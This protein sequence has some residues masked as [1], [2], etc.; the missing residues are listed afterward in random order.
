M[1]NVLLLIIV[2]SL[3][4]CVS[5]SREPSQPPAIPTEE[6]P[7]VLTS[8]P[9]HEAFAEPVDLNIQP[10][11]IVPAQPPANIKETLPAEK[12]S[13]Q[14]VWVPG[15][16]AWD[17]Q[18]N[19]Y[20]WVSGCWRTAP[21]NMYWVPG[22]WLK[23]SDGWQ[24]VSGF[25]APTSGIGRIEYLP[26]PPELVDIKPPVITVSSDKIWVP[27]CW[28]WR[29]G[30]YIL[31]S[32]Y[33]VT[34]QPDWIWEPSHYVWTPRG[35]VF[36]AGHWDYVLS[37][38]GVLFAP[39][40][41]PGRVYERPDFSYSLS[42]VIDIGNLNFGLF[43]YPHY[44]HYY[45]GDY[46]DD[47]YLSIGI[48]PW[49]ESRSRYVWY[50]P[51]YEHQHWRYSRGEP[52]WEK[53]HRDD[54]ERRRADRSLRP[55]RTYREMEARVEKMP[56]IK[57]TEYWTAAPLKTVITEKRDQIR[58]EPM[59]NDSRQRISRKTT[60]V[61]DFG[62]ERKQWESEKPIQK[63]SKEMSPPARANV[64]ERVKTTSPP[65]SDKQG[66]FDIFRKGP[67]SR[68]ANEKRTEAGGKQ[69]QP[70]PGNN[71]DTPRQENRRDRR[72]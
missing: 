13:G 72:G 6:N 55:A 58:F 25:W 51:I 69:S 46:Y 71:S 56:F 49:F 16:W 47:V 65:I 20:I 17:S 23:I 15:Y 33:W 32:G 45:F 27:P 68:P 5:Y 2:T 35:Y 4:P 54:Y 29:N 19:S 67:P 66:I 50:D 31:R 44:R 53:H 34:A 7:E 21:P 30:K 18:R 57:Q 70:E 61:R 59:S 38:R 36:V 8:G 52:Q 37:K 10:G 14:F 9:M 28:Y 11:I 62:I 3:M 22:Y 60:D 43:A 26:E 42:I 1:K 12:P 40:Y 39:V 24:W 64:P 48:L 41:F 63:E